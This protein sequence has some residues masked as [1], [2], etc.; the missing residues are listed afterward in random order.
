MNLNNVRIGTRLA[1]GFGAVLALLLV[2]V[3]IAYTQ[4]NRTNGGLAKLAALERRAGIAREW[5][6]KTQINVSRS[7][8]IAKAKSQPEIEKYFGP[9]IK[10]TSAEIST[11]QKSM[12]TLV[13]DDEGSKDLLAKV[14]NQRAAYV[15]VRGQL[16]E[17]VKQADAPAAEALLTNKMLPA[18]EAYLAAMA[19]VQE[20]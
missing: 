3:G 13:A 19:A 11:L 17:F 18:S 12:E 10:A 20:R 2:I 9:L 7:V 1:I 14:A 6:S 5:A 4:L 16:L 15:A 8:A